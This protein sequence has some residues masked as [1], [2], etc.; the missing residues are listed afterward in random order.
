MTSGYNLG[1]LVVVIGVKTLFEWLLYNPQM[2]FFG[3]KEEFRY[4]FGKELHCKLEGD[5]W[6]F[7]LRFQNL[8]M[9]IKWPD[10]FSDMQYCIS[11]CLIYFYT[12]SKNFGSIMLVMNEFIQSL[13]VKFVLA[14]S[15]Q[16]YVRCSAEDQGFQMISIGHP[17]DTSTVLYNLSKNAT[18]DSP[19]F[20]G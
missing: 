20:R 6:H 17:C 18:R 7:F 4:N 19:T 8:K 12:S 14:R 16:N 9:R 1:H 10:R 13:S 11:Q 15:Q 5:F 3:L 2:A